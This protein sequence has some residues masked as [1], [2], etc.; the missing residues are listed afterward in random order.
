MM[1]SMFLAMTIAGLWHGAAWTFVVFGVLH[2]AAIVI[3]HNWK[4]YKI[5]LPVY[6]SWPLTFIFVSMCFTMFRAKTVEQAWRIYKGMFGFSGFQLP[7]G[8]LSTELMNSWGIKYG[9]HMLN[10]ENIHLALIIICFFSVR[11]MKNSVEHAQEFKRTHK[12]ALVTAM[13][14]VLCL[15]GLNRL[16]EF[17]Y[18]NF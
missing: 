9:P 3:H 8:I 1:L 11:K 16:T 14:F 17:I 12:E 4:K 5:K 13:M 2:G 6:I 15:F 10:D 7:K 18:F